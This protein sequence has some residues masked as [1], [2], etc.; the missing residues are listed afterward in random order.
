MNLQIQQDGLLVESK[1]N[2][3]GKKRLGIYSTSF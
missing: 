1:T 2:K 3:Y